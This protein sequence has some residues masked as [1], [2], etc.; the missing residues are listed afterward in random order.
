MK[1]PDCLNVHIGGVMQQLHETGI[2]LPRYDQ[3]LTRLE[4]HSKVANW[5]VY[6]QRHHWQ[7]ENTEKVF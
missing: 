4:S 7:N 5:L 3:Y 6:A 1:I 2:D